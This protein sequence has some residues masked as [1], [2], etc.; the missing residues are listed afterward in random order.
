MRYNIY[1]ILLLVILIS[2]AGCLDPDTPNPDNGPVKDVDVQSDQVDVQADQKDV[3]VTDA[4]DSAEKVSPPKFTATPTDDSIYLIM[5]AVQDKTVTVE[6][7]AHD[8]KGVGLLSFRVKYDPTALNLTKVVPAPLFGQADN[9]GVFM[10][11]DMKDGTIS[12]GGAYFGLKK[13][14]DFKD[15]LI[16]TLTFTVLQSKTVDLT[17]PAGYVLV[18]DKN[19]KPVSVTF[20]NSSLS[21]INKNSED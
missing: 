10:A 13:T 16:T 4:A 14:V 2:I 17:F 19:R 3:Q 6:I 9:T 15:D 8:I 18:L 20:I 21:F 1:R 12:L 7:R 11:K 5:K